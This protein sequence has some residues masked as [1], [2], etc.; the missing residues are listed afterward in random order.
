MEAKKILLGVSGSIAAFKAGE[1]ASQLVKLGHTVDV[2]MTRHATEFITP[3][4]MQ[5][6]TRRAVLVSLD[7]EKQSWKPGH[8][9][10]AD[11]CDLFVCA[12]AT[13]N[14]LANFAHGHAPDS[15]SSTYLALPRTTPV[16]LVPAMNGKMW[17]HPATQRNVE[18]LKADGCDFIGPAAGDLACGYQGMGRMAE[19]IDIVRHITGEPADA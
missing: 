9:E 18:I 15:L 4:T 19:P 11:T 12:P 8:I 16:F 2:V 6:L 17:F 13:A 5:T 1:I 7:D 3:L 14:I 10:L